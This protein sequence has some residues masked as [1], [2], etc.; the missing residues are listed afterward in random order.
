MKHALLTISVLLAAIGANAQTPL[1]TGTGTVP[2]DGANRHSTS[3][4]V[5]QQYKWDVSVDATFLLPRINQ[6]VIYSPSTYASPLD[7]YSPY[8]VGRS[9]TFML[10]KNEVVRNQANVPIRRGA[11]R[12]NLNWA[13]DYGLITQDSL[14]VLY[15][16][17]S[18]G[19][20]VEKEA[21]YAGFGISGG[22]EWQQQFGRF[23]LF[24]GAD[25]FVGHFSDKRTG[26]LF[27]S[28]Y[29]S[30]GGAVE[31][32]RDVELLMRRTSI[33]IAP[34]AGVKYF[35]HPRVSFSIESTAYLRYTWNYQKTD[36]STFVPQRTAKGQGIATSVIPI[37]AFNLT[38]HFGQINQ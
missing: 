14:R 19:I 1:A 32:R 31:R 8:D 29:T 34:L 13:A 27:Y 6:P 37:S 12:L 33:G 36:Y 22:Y 21:R 10:R 20:V 4:F 5:F 11:Y 18:S 30:T 25:A 3:S 7:N 26:E 38:F 2:A 24:Y 35:L 15:N 9:A 16:F 17:G 28:E 23:Q